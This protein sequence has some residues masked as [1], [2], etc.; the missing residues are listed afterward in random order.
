MTASPDDAAA[1]DAPPRADAGPAAPSFPGTPAAGPSDDG[2]LSD[3][4]TGPEPHGGPSRPWWRRRGVLVP[5][6]VLVVLAV[7]YGA[8]LL[9][10][11]GSVARSTVVAGVDLGGLSPAAAA[12]ALEAELAPRLATDRTVVADDVTATLSPVAAGLTLDVDATVDRA[13]DQP[14]AP[15]T[16]LVSLFADRDVAPVLSVDRAALDAQLD[17]LAE[18]VDRPPVDATLAVDGTTPRLVEPVD[19]RELD[20]RDAAGALID[21]LTGGAEPGSPVELPVRVAAPHVDRATA[22]Q[23]LEETV[24]PALAAPVEVTTEDGSASTEVS[25][26]ALAASLTF[27]PQENGDLDVGIDPAALQTALG[28][29]IEAFGTPAE[30]A[31]FDVSGGK[32]SVV[33][34]VDGTGIDP[35]K[36]AEQLLPVLTAPAPRSVTATLGPVPAELTTAEAQALG[37]REQI[38]TFTTHYTA[39]ASGANM[40][41]AAAKI[42]GTIVLPGETFSLN[43]ATGPRGRAQGYVE[44]GVIS[45]GDFTTS[46]GGGVSQLATTIFNA[47]F[48]AGL[49]DVHHKPHSYY[50]SRYPPGREATVWYD[51]LD[52]KWRNDGDT[53]VLVDTAWAPGSLTVTFYGTKRYEIE[54]VTSDRYDLTS[55]SVQVEPDD[56][57]CHGAAGSSGFSVTVTRVFHD[58]TTGAEIRREDFR[59]RYAAQPTVRC[60]AAAPRAPAEPGGAAPAAD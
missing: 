25:V 41:R 54:S 11:S 31:R 43:E 49:E 37:I 30:D 50:I 46:V 12:R 13:V 4:P 53:G 15:W 7:V 59:T 40:R 14:L 38:S 56:G 18:Q 44:A 9:V 55:P 27:T 60:V 10:T 58:P 5:V 17:R 51:S 42:D 24:T 26:P 16:R 23:V 8:D 19:G 3:D 52:L 20:R 32:V 21:A 34:A 45:G 35:A 57:D 33:P 39:A 22:Q 1:S 48:F 36:L 29:Q 6:L 28:D 47:V 2:P